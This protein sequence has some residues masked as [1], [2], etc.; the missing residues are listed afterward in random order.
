MLTTRHMDVI[1]M[2]AGEI[3][4]CVSH[5]EL[6][7]SAVTD[8]FIR[9]I[10]SVNPRLNAVVVPMFESARAEAAELDRLVANG[11]PVGPLAGV[12]FTVK[13]SF[14][15]QGTPTTAG[16]TARR[17]H[18]AV[19]DSLM[20]RRLR[21]SGGVLL[22]KTN[23][24]PLLLSTE[25][26]NPLYGRTN[27]P[28][29]L[30]RTPG[31]SSGGEGAIIAVKG[32]ALGL[33]SDLG[34]SVRVPANACGIHALRPTSGRLSML[35]HFDFRQG[36]EEVLAQPGPLARSVADLSL[37]MSVLAA[38]G[39]DS[40]DVTIPHVPWKEPTGVPVLQLRIAYFTDNGIFSP[41]PA[42]RRAVED[43]ASVLA[44]MGTHVEE[45]H[46][47]SLEEAWDVCVRLL[48]AD[49]MRSARRALAGSTVGPLTRDVVSPALLPRGIIAPMSWLLA[50]FGQ[51]HAAQGFARLRKLSA[52]QYFRL[53]QRRNDFRDRFLAALEAGRIDALLCPAD[54]LAAVPHGSSRFLGNT[55]SYTAVFSLLGMP[56]GV[57]SITRVRNSEESAR[58]K[59]FDVAERTAQAAERGS[60]GLP[61]G[62]QV[63][64][65][66]WREDVVLAVMAALENYY[67]HTPE[68]PA[69]PSL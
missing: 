11:T 39:Q 25:T 36:H 12:P 17:N 55:L 48:V 4:A 26:D 68:Y 16:L 63:L 38:P 41:C 19:A 10:E 66:H 35:G 24:P 50:V 56:A 47:P 61:V 27:N 14:D 57:V 42:I 65:R 69:E 28:W 46:G 23:V 3:A 43:A 7:A 1:S 45:W 30:Q 51:K 32:S 40:Y 31:G 52:D 34:G 54:A 37:A 59:S 13:E 58:P 18:I 64:A 22:G 60:A 29:D 67:R 62:A 6:S 5:G 53:V 15:V 44:G 20:V 9:R 21:E 2:S 49:G 33:G 8:A